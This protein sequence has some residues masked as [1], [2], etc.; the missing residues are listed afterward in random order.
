MKLNLNH[1][2]KQINS[3]YLHERKFTRKKRNNLKQNQINA[4]SSLSSLTFVCNAS[5]E[6]WLDT[7]SRSPLTGLVF[8]SYQGDFH[9][10]TQNCGERIR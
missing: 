3:K 4:C 2:E 1:I 9:E 5:L 7:T 6:F 8:I 10:Q